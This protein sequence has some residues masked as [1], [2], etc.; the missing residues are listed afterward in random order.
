MTYKKNTKIIATLGPASSTPQILRQL[1]QAGANVF[2]FNF[3]HGSHETHKKNYEI[4]RN[5]EA[6]LNQP[7]GILM[8]LQGP[9]IRIGQFEKGPIHLSEGQKFRL[10]LDATLG[11][12]KRVSLP[13]PFVFES[14]KPKDRLLLDDGKI[15]LQ[16][17]TCGADF[18]E[19]TV[20]VGG[21][22][23][24]RK[25][26][27]IPDGTLPLS[28]LT[29][30]DRQDLEFGLNLG[31]DWV[32]LSFVQTPQDIIEARTL[33]QGKARIIAKIEKPMALSYLEEIIEL[34]D[35]IMIA[36]GDLGVEMLPE[37]VPG[38]QKKI[39]KL[40]RQKGRP[41]VVATQMLESMIQL[42]T[43]T[44]AEA[45]D[46]ATAIFEG[47]DAVM[48]SAESASGNYPVESVTMMN[49]VILKVEQD[50]LYRN[51]LEIAQTQGNHTT[52]DALT[53]SA[54]HVAQTIPISAIVTFTD[55]GMTA[56]R[57]ARE[58]PACPILGLSP[59]ISTVRFLTLVWGVHPHQTPNIH[60]FDEMTERAT[61]IAQETGFSSPEA[62][63][64]ILAG[65]PFGSPG[66]T[67]ILRI[68]TFF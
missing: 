50:P 41:V 10:D 62:S 45:S 42:P 56:L 5:L 33:I 46:V 66:H 17:E 59:K 1:V 15:R 9:K 63:L 2:R 16:V 68:K 4:L 24:E 48:L 40:C 22:L 21:T 8:D 29:P 65:V 23:S 47:A 64:A 11:D 44:R 52:A 38:I 13:H 54:R 67:N 60:D 12:E 55:T 3:S 58:R 49:R 57:M 18:A 19:T 37:E 32:A 36:R 25:G 34:S 27:N 61:Q 14:L 31:V 39:I 53:G 28:P 30:K 43:P 51:C 7:I 6:D 20:M 35:G 26:V